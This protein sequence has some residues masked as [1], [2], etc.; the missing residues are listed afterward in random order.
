MKKAMKNPMLQNLSLVLVFT[1]N[2][3]LK[4][5][6][7]FASNYII[8]STLSLTL[9]LSPSLPLCLSQPLQLAD[10]RERECERERERDRL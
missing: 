2:Q 7:T 5:T 6:Q 4:Q 10:E 1:P 9:S 8:V 3:R